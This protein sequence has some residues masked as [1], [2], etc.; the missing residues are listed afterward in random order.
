MKA[1]ENSKNSICFF[2]ES[3]RN[4]YIDLSFCFDK[5]KSSKQSN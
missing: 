4:A 2:G 5:K 3:F 1:L